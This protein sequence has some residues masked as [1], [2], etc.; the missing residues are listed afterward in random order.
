MLLMSY[1]YYI[2]FEYWLGMLVDYVIL[3]KYRLKNVRTSTV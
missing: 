1:C 3:K 2:V